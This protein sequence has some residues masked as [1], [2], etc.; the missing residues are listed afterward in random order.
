MVVLTALAFMEWIGKSGGMRVL[1][2]GSE[3]RVDRVLGWWGWVVEGEEGVVFGAGFAAAEVFA[4]EAEDEDPGEAETNEEG[5]EE[6]VHE[7]GMRAGVGKGSTVLRG[8]LR[9]G[10]ETPRRF[11]GVERATAAAHSSMASPMI[12]TRGAS[13]IWGML[14]ERWQLAQR[15]P[16]RYWTGEPARAS[17]I[18]A[19]WAASVSARAAGPAS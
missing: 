7:V 2:E 19:R 6:S 4:E 10:C 3:G 9:R 17:R 5:D 16:S 18:H 12:W 11:C 13:A 14:M 8:V 15:L 1:K